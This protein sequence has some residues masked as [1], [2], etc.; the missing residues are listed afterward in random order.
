[1]RK[2]YATIWNSEQR[3]STLFH[4]AVAAELLGRP[5]DSAE[6]VHHIDGNSLNNSPDNLLVLRSQRHH[7]SLEQ[8]LRRARRGQPT[9]FPSL[10]EGIREWSRG[11]LFQQLQ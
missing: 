1:M 5:L 8:Y 11:T 10:P 4:R 6:V 9:L 2:K 7:A 3:R